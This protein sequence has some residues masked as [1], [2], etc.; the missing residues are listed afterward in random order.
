MEQKRFSPPVPDSLC[1]WGTPET[2][3]RWFCPIPV[4]SA[5]LHR[6]QAGFPRCFWGVTRGDMSVMMRSRGE[7]QQHTHIKHPV[8]E[9]D[10]QQLHS[11][12]PISLSGCNP[13][14]RAEAHPNP[15]ANPGTD[16]S[17]EL[18]PDVKHCWALQWE[19]LG[20][21]CSNGMGI[22]LGRILCTSHSPCLNLQDPPCAALRMLTRK[23]KPSHTFLMESHELHGGCRKQHF[24]I[25]A[26]NS[27]K[28]S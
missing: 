17:I 9:P 12:P 26:A 28:K 6:A 15:A 4:P 23:R 27:P 13:A 21:V 20:Q 19:E 7:Q 5:S 16:Q 8:C 3:H 24:H 22:L 14:I 25:T 18:T 11:S 10:V 1:Q 2:Q